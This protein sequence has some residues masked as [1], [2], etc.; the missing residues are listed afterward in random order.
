[1]YYCYILFSESLNKYYVGS[2]SDLD[3]SLRKHNLG[4]AKFTSTGIP[5]S[6][7]WC[8]KFDS[9]SDAL[10]REKEIKNRKSRIFIDKLIA[11]NNRELDQFQN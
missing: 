9:N 10:K 4:H 2:C 8:E 5:W 7:M 11:K 1:M 6:L 3:N